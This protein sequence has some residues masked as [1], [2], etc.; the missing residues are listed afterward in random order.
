MLISRDID[1]GMNES[2]D[3]SSSFLRG[4]ERLT[5]SHSGHFGQFRGKSP[6]VRKYN[7][8]LPSAAFHKQQLPR[9]P[10]VMTSRPVREAA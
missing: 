5:P 7:G 6:L 2:S 4:M 1:T 3:F 10:T 8:G 9:V